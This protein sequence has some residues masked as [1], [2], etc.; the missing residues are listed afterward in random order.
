MIDLKELH[1]VLCQLGITANYS[2]SRLIIYAILLADQDEDRLRLI[3]KSLYPDV[4][5]HFNVNES[6]VERNIRTAV[7]IAWKKNPIFLKCISGYPLSKRPSN[8]EF[9]SIL[10]DYIS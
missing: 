7:G 4:A 10:L 1:T 8:I 3:T 6:S 5:K 2:G 9:L